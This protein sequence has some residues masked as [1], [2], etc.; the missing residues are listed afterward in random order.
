MTSNFKY[1]IM[2]YINKER[3]LVI[4][5]DLKVQ[6]VYNNGKEVP[7]QFEIFYEENNKYYKIFQSYSS[8][9]IKWENKKIIE[10]GGDWEYSKTTGKYRN[11]LTGMDKKAFEK[12]LKNEF[13]FNEETQTYIRNI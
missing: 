7:N 4:M 13:T 11:I 6:N 1:S 2:N 10:V 9:I 12:M 8:M 3:E 5:K